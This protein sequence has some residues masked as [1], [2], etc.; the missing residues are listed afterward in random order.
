MVSVVVPVYN[1][2]KY[3]QKCID[4]IISQNYMDLQILLIDDGSTDGSG[5]ICDEFAGKDSRIEVFHVENSGVSEARNRGITESKGEYIAF[6]DSDDFVGENHIRSLADAQEKE[7]NQTLICKGYTYFKQNKFITNESA[8]RTFDVSEFYELKSNWYINSPVNKLYRRD[9]IQ[10]SNITFPK[11][12]SIGEDLIF[13]LQYLKHSG[14]KRI[15]LLEDDDYYYRQDTDSSLTKKYYPEYYKISEEQYH[16]TYDLMCELGAPDNHFAEFEKNHNKFLVDTLFYNVYAIKSKW[17]LLKT[18]TE[19]MKM[20]NVAAIVKSMDTDYCIKR[21]LKPL[22]GFN[23]YYLIYLL[24]P[25]LDVINAV[26]H[27]LLGD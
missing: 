5:Q 13:N 25:V 12:I 9:V 15:R 27:K 8:D 20:H 19:I 17:E 26:R 2:A 23:N 10:S 24:E 18:N 6:V 16:L 14:V 21:Y 1:S 22:Y 11:E 3:L 7:G 4:S